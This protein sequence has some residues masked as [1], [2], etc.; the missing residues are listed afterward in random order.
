MKIRWK[1]IK[2]LVKIF[3]PAI[4]ISQHSMNINS[5]HFITP[6][7]F[8]FNR[9]TQFESLQI[10]PPNLNA[11]FNAMNNKI[12]PW[13]CNGRLHAVDIFIFS[14]GQAHV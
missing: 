6:S 9:M 3:P 8:S 1:Q 2:I 4:F 5:P 11:W 13:M 14:R 7:N 10:F 12:L